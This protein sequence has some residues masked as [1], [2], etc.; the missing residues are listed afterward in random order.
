MQSLI[1]YCQNGRDNRIQR[2]KS[3]A[4]LFPDSKP[5]LVELLDQMLEI[6]PYFR[7]TAKD[8]LRNKIFD[9]VR[10]KSAELDAPYKI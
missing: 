10:V 3:V 5:E 1:E 2:N 6:N 7:P 4:E 8:L 9:K